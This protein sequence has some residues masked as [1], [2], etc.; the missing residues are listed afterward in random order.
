MK[1]EDFVNHIVFEKINQF[2]NRFQEEVVRT[3]IE[4][5]RLVFFETVIKYISD[6]LKITIP[7][8]IQDAEMNALA[9][10]L[11]AGLSQIN[12]FIGNNNIGHL[13]NANNNF[14]SALNRIRNF[15]L[16]LTKNKFNFSKEIAN[17]EKTL[18]EKYKS[19]E[20]ER[21]EINVKLEQLTK[22]I[23]SKKQ[24]IESL[25][26]LLTQKQ[27]EINTLTNSFKAEL[28]NLKT[29][30]VQQFE[31]ER[32]TFRQE[33]NSDRNQFEQDRENY[34]QEILKDRELYRKE[35]D[36][37]K[38]AI[39]IKTKKIVEELKIKLEESKKLVNVIGNIGVTGNYQEI[40][41]YHRKQANTWRWIALFFMV[42]LTGLLIFTIYHITG[43]DFNWKVAVVRVV[44]FSAL[45][46]PATYA[47]KEAGTHRRLENINRKLELDLASIN[48]FIEILPESKKQAIKEKMVEKFFGNKDSEFESK[49]GSK[50][51]ISINVFEKLLNALLPFIK[52]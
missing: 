1:P 25:N 6:R 22:A 43:G 29:S 40:A 35:I 39:S 47:A 13:N 14:N 27:T 34:K 37:L 51:E 11:E 5:E 26:Q 10:E 48:P 21:K 30:E 19:L 52:R 41:N 32:K 44:A 31:Q 15:P 16:P 9:N 38:E 3:K 20:Q 23:E 33:I 49:V 45:L 36:E 17:F 42:L 8:L 4:L 12:A 50:E 2:E 28:E 46:Y 7:I 18:S 24:E